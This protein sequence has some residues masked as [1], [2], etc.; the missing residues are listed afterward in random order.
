MEIYP[1]RQAAAQ[2]LEKIQQF[3]TQSAPLVGRMG[4][5]RFQMLF[6]E[7]GEGHYLPP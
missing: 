6:L 4:K 1:A 7:N 3:G 5:E 2:G